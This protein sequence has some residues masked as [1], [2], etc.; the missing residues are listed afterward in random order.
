[1]TD[2]IAAKDSVLKKINELN[3]GNDQCVILDE[4]TIRVQDGWIFFYQ[5]SK[6]LQTGE[7]SHA[8]VGNIPIFVDQETGLLYSLGISAESVDDYATQYKS[9]KMLIK[10]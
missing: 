5:S 3:S 2:F 1:M 4:Q 6:F 7:I 10:W 8:L 9:L